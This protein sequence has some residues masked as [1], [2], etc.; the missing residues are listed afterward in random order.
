MLHK[1]ATEGQFMLHKKA[2]DS[3]FLPV[4]FLCALASLCASG[5]SMHIA[6]FLPALSKR[7]LRGR[8]GRA[9]AHF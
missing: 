5:A 6:Q 4:A 7:H 8:I 3:H 1:K 9:L 2:T